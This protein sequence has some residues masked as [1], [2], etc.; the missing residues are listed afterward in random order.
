MGFMTTELTLRTGAMSVYP[1]SKGLESLYTFKT[2]FEDEV[3]G[4]VRQGNTLL[5]PRESVPYAPSGCDFRVSKVAQPLKVEF[6]PRSQE[7]A[8]LT[9]D[10][11]RW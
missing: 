2:A 1:Y 9:M 4:A 10:R 7:Q 3:C 5:V 8:D 11:P 6:L